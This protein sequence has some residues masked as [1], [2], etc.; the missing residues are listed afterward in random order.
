[1][2]RNTKP[3]QDF[4]REVG[5]HPDELRQVL[6]RVRD[7]LRANPNDQ[8]RS[9]FLG[10]FHLRKEKER[11]FW[12]G[13][14]LRRLPPRDA[15]AMKVLSRQSEVAAEFKSSNFY[16]LRLANIFAQ[17]TN[18]IEVTFIIVNGGFRRNSFK[19]QSTATPFLVGAEFNPT[20]NTGVALTFKVDSDAV[21][22]NGTTQAVDVRALVDRDGSKFTLRF[23]DL[24]RDALRFSIGVHLDPELHFLNT[25]FNGA[26]RPTTGSPDWGEVIHAKRV[27]DMMRANAAGEPFEPGG[28]SGAG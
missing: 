18:D 12:R 6:R 9:N 19:T 27:V 23:D 10:R 26:A 4:A 20:A 17:A 13:D 8:V 3:M 15:I 28:G 11:F 5:V 21:P 24:S 16:F 22:G 14:T 1:M 2:P 25:N 7:H